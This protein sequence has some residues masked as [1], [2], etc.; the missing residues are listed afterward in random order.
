MPSYC[1]QP[2]VMLPLRDVNETYEAETETRPRRWS[3]ELETRPRDW[4][5]GIETRPR[6]D[7]QN[8]VS[9]RL[10]ETYKP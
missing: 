9:R 7:V 10:V 4:S 5:D 6:R 2:C 3:V 8:N 1:Y